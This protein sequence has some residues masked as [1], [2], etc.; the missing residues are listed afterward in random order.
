MVTVGGKLDQVFLNSIVLL[1]FTVS[2]TIIPM[3]KILTKCNGHWE[4]S[5]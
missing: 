4:A 2:I 1:A 5:N 3:N